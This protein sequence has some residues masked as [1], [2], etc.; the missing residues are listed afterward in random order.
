[1]AIL[2]KTL[3]KKIKLYSVRLI[4]PDLIFRPI[5]ALKAITR[6]SAILTDFSYPQKRHSHQWLKLKDIALKYDLYG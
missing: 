3:K 2:S 4:L 6:F 1:M 5:G